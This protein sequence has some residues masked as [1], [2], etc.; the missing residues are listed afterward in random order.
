MTTKNFRNC[1]FKELRDYVTKHEGWPAFMRLKGVNA[2]SVKLPDLIEFCE[3]A[4]IEEIPT[5]VPEV[6]AARPAPRPTV[7]SNDPAAAL[8]AAIQAIAGTS[9]NRDEVAAIVQDEINKALANIPTIKIELKRHDGTEHKTEGMHHPQFPVLLKVLSARDPS[10]RV[11]NVWLA[12]PTATGKTTMAEKAAEALGLPFY[13]H[14]AMEMAHELLGFVDAGGTYHETQFVKCFRNGGVVLLDE[15]DSWESGATLA[16][17][18]ALANG[19]MSLPN[20]SMLKRHG[21]CIVIGAGNTWGNGATA[22]FMG[23]KKLDAAF[24]SRFP[25]KLQIDYDVALEQ[26]FTG[27]KAWA[28]RVQAARARARSVGLKHVID[29]RHSLAGAALIAQGF[30]AD[31]AAKLTYLAG[32]APE[33]V[34]QVEGRSL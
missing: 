9:V 20:A 4:K 12:G 8:M 11:P 34:E 27:N 32:L 19:Q 21:D 24:L 23:R 3:G 28:R 33:Q 10:G 5:D 17:N 14:G 30:S 26:A 25:V 15:I 29:P 18:A 2:A 7:Q 22:E 6:G 1:S 13:M 16:L 31:E